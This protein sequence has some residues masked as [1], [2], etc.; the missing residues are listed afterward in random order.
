MLETSLAVLGEICSLLSLAHSRANFPGFL[1]RLRCY[2]S[3]CR[4]RSRLQFWLGLVFIDSIILASSAV[5]QDP[6]TVGQ[7]SSVM[8]WPN[9]AVHAH[10]LP[11]GKVL[12]WPSWC[13]GENST[14]RHGSTTTTT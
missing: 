3:C 9:Q 5:A 11:T 8:T 14:L 2:R 1:R 13:E 7:F 6:A 10:L 12:W 4:A